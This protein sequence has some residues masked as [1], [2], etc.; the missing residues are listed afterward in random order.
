MKGGEKVEPHRI[1]MDGWHET[2]EKLSSAQMQNTQS[3]HAGI[4]RTHTHARKI[5]AR[6]GTE[7]RWVKEIRKKPEK[8]QR[9]TTVPIAAK[10]GRY[11]CCRSREMR[12]RRINPVNRSEQDN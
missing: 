10:S 6:S 3:Q 9:E 12:C 4:T 11:V 1:T 8:R 5:S 2:R 7:V